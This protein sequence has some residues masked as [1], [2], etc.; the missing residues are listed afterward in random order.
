MDFDVVFHE[1]SEYVIGFQIRG[2]NDELST[3]FRKHAFLFLQKMQKK[4]KKYLTCI[5]MKIESS[6]EK[7]ITKMISAK[8]STNPESF[9]GLGTVYKFRIQKGFSK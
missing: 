7:F 6:S 5:F 4:S 2:T 3:I 9:S 8:N 1:E